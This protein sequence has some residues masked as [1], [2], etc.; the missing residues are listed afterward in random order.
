MRINVLDEKNY[1][2]YISKT[3]ILYTSTY[4]FVADVT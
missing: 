3:Y 4:E 2:L 1:V